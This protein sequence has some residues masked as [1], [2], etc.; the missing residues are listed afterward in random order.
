MAEQPDEDGRTY[1][2]VKKGIL[3][4]KYYGGQDDDGV[5]Q[6]VVPKGLREKVVALVH[7]TLLAGHIGAAVTLSRVQQEFY[8]RAV[9]GC[10]TRYMASCDL[11]Q[12]NVSR[13]TVPKALLGKLPSVDTSFSVICVDIIGP[14]NRDTF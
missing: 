9:H 2:F 3:Y 5:V 4:R 8:W 14:M 7:D 6:L 12:R 10:V 13:G 11:C 1:F